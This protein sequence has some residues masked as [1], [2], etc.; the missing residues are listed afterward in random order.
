MHNFTELM[1]LNKFFIFTMLIYNSLSTLWYELNGNSKT[2][3]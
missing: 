2:A 3:I 1:V